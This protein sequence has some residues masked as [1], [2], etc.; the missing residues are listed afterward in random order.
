MKKIYITGING[1]LGSALVKSL[2]NKYVIKGCDITGKEKVD[3]TKKDDLKK[4]VDKFNPDYIIHCASLIDIDYCQ[5]HKAE[6]DKVNVYGTSNV[7][8]LG[9][10]VIYI[11]THAVYSGEGAHEETDALNPK[12]Y[13]STTKMYGE[14]KTNKDDLILRVNIIG[15]QKG[16]LQW[17]YSNLEAGKIIGAFKDVVFQPLNV[18]QV[19]AIIDKLKDKSGVYNIGCN[20]PETKHLFAYKLAKRLS[21]R[22]RNIAAINFNN[23]VDRPRDLSVNLSKVKKIMEMPS[24]DDVYKSCLSEYGEG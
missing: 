14:E 4:D 13:Y 19:G 5:S 16:F 12:N 20:D 22:P 18:N 8:S 24:L 9:Y 7:C 1:M 11:S 6:A 10:K 23:E 2:E 21:L 17:M 15:K 3:I